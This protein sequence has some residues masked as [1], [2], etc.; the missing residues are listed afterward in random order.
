[1]MTGR[2]YSERL[3]K[4][5]AAI[6]IVCA[7]IVFTLMDELGTR[8][9]PMMRRYAQYT[10]HPALQNLQVWTTA[11]A[12]LLG[13]GQVILAANLL[14]SLRYGEKVDNP[15]SELVERQGMPS[16]EWN[17]L[18]Y[19]VPTPENFPYYPGASADGGEPSAGVSDDD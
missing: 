19:E 11:F 14:W 5:H 13:I 12:Y 9:V 1:R 7:P 10:Y 17:G 8:A 2:M 3:G 18:P 15:W 16:P 6:T 4:L